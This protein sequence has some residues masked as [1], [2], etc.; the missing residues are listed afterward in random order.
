MA[1][2]ERL[3]KHA[4]GAMIGLAIGDALGMPTQS[5]SAERIIEC[6]GGPVRRL[7]D[8][9]P[10]QPIAPNMKAGSV[11]D[12]TEQAFVLAARL[13]E[14]HGRIDNDAYAQDLLRWEAKMKE[15]GSLDL[16][17]PSTKAAL[18]ALA[19]GIDPE[20]TGRFGTTNGGA[21]RATP[22]ASPSFPETLGRGGLAFLRGDAQ[23]HAG[24]RIDH[25]GGRRREPRHRGGARLPFESVGVRGIPAAARQLVGQGVRRRPREDVHG[26]GRQRRRLHVRREFAT[27]LRRDCGT[28]VEANESVAA[29]FAIATRF[30]DK[31]TEA[32]CFAASLGGDTDTIA[33]ITGA[34]LGA[35]HGPDG[36]DPDMRGQVLRQLKDDDRLDLDRTVAGLCALREREA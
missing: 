7:M 30:F 33:A 23:H 19:E 18:Q 2:D 31:P 35:W 25:A 6:Y 13:I 32:L 14:D 26:M 4:R 29:A 27:I 9:V 20:L 5:M 34:M 15:K 1:I 28:S 17:G 11:T 36:F 24:H 16:L 12:D 10:Q 22:V 8:A 21:M 3:M